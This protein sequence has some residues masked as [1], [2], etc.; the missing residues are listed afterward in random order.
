MQQFH[1]LKGCLTRYTPSL[2]ALSRVLSTARGDTFFGISGVVTDP[3]SMARDASRS[4]VCPARIKFI[5]EYGTLEATFDTHPFPALESIA[6]DPNHSRRV[7]LINLW[8][9]AQ[10]DT[11][12]RSGVTALR[13]ANIEL[14]DKLSG[15][16]VANDE[17]SL[18]LIFSD[19]ASPIR[20]SVTSVDP[21]VVDR[22]AHTQ[23]PLT[24]QPLGSLVDLVL[25]G[26]LCLAKRSFPVRA[27]HGLKPRDVLV[28]WNAFY[29]R[30][31]KTLSA[32]V[33]WGVH[34]RR[35][36]TV[37]VE[38][39]DKN[40]TVTSAPTMNQPHFDEP[41]EATPPILDA[42]LPKDEVSVPHQE[43]LSELEVPVHLE[44]ST[45]QLSLRTLA[46]L[47]PG[48]LMELP[49]PIEDTDVQLV[50]HGQ[51][52]GSG[53]LVAI[54]ENLGLQISHIATM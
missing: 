33:T 1:E 12:L 52:I 3:K 53:R 9:N 46:S 20:C 26:R 17:G 19:T 4:S 47:K 38:I 25:P 50:V 39:L 51:A 15:P 37:P 49:T 7:A 34:S 43:R 42:G 29:P 27:L 5:C 13:I 36:F 32:F 48:F 21:G 54:G 30:P 35:R 45:L 16:S 10:L 44:I 31:D 11:S 14:S 22:L 2:A 28:G 41:N 18:Q 40:L 8:F 23:K 24:F 6:S